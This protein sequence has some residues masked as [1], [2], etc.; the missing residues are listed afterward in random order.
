MHK[1]VPQQTGHPLCD[2]QNPA[3]IHVA[4]QH[5]TAALRKAAEHTEKVLVQ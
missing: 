4:Q 1:R 3:N 2:Q 5:S